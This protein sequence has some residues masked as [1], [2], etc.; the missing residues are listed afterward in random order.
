MSVAPA[1]QRLVETYLKSMQRGPSG[2][3][4]LV[5]VFADDAVYVE[6]FSGNGRPA[7]HRGKAVIRQFFQ[8][9]LP[10]NPP[11]F[12]VT[13]N[14]L[15]LDG[16]QLRADWTCTGSM[17]P[18]PMRGYDLYTIRNGKV[19]RLETYLAPPGGYSKG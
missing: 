15:V 12:T 4:D 19:A 5:S 7:E 2:L 17:F 10:R 13:L 6:P 16:E 9:S 18:G 11:D 14:R 3:D 8:G 1:D